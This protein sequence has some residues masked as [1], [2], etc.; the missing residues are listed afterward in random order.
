M[1]STPDGCFFRVAKRPNESQ[2]S[3]DT[4]RAKIHPT[5]ASSTSTSSTASA[6]VTQTPPMILP[7]PPGG[8][9]QTK[10][11][12]TA[13]SMPNPVI[14]AKWRELEAQVQKLERDHEAAVTQGR[15]DV[16]AQ[17][18]NERDKMFANLEKFKSAVQS[19][20]RVQQQ[21]QAQTLRTQSGSQGQQAQPQPLPANPS[22]SAAA[23][24]SS[25]QTSPRVAQILASSTMVTSAAPP[26]LPRAP[27]MPGRTGAPSFPQM[28]TTSSGS[29]LPLPAHMTPEMASQMQKLVDNHGIRPRQASFSQPQPPQKNPAPPS[30]PMPGPSQQQSTNSTWE[31]ALTWTGFD[32]TTHDRKEMHAQVSVASHSGDMYVSFRVNFEDFTF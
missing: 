27:I 26:D 8:P 9:A 6:P 28:S 32:V 31:G 18:K 23:S 5:P 12:I 19:I 29:N 13:R 14:I 3:P 24:G 7:Q 11:V 16:A 2:A 10:A 22:V 15:M 4:K 17:I 21:Q 25:I 1:S 30:Q 20:M